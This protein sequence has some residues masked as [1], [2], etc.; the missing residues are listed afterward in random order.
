[1]CASAHSV[2]GHKMCGLH[3]LRSSPCQPFGLLRAAAAADEGKNLWID[4]C[5]IL[6]LWR[7][8]LYRRAGRVD[9]E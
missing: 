1:M 3:D 4:D 2:I 7:V 8:H 6:R 5:E 9:G